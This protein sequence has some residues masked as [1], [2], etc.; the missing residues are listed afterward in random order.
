MSTKLNTAGV[1]N[2]HSLVMQG[3]VNTGT[4]DFT[5]EDGNKLLGP[6]GDDWANY[7]KSFL[8]THP[9]QP[10]MTKAHYGYP[11]SKNG[12]V[13]RNA[14]VSAKGRAAGQGAAEVEAACSSLL[15]MMDKKSGQPAVAKDA[16]CV[17]AYSLLE[18]KSIDEDQRTF[19]GIATTPSTDRMD[20]IVE[21]MGA[22][23]T[24][25]IP[26]LWQHGR[27]SIS[28][29][30]GQIT[31][32]R[33]TSS[34][35]YVKGQMQKPAADYPQTLRDDLNKAWVL[36]RDK[37]VRGLSIGFNSLESEPIKGSFGNRYTKWDWL[38][39]SAVTI[40]A[41]QDASIQTVKSL[42]LIE[43]GITPVR[44]V[45]GIPLG[46]KPGVFRLPK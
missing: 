42:A 12:E 29:P 2:A 40:A 21:P 36:V 45:K 4:W 46:P 13:Y 31:S 27:G 15:D 30:V 33:A 9:N 43:R 18:I 26:M 8:A 39:L 37:L 38:E 3:K 19:E 24:L 14:V 5:A 44:V 25:P 34:G 6:N 35:I 41:N 22:Q 7:G 16:Q 23:F 11:V 28:D 17:R 20:D 32:A 10:S 1:A